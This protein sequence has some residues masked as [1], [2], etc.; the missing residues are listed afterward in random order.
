MVEGRLDCENSRH[1]T[2]VGSHD[3]GPWSRVCLQ[4]CGFCYHANVCTKLHLFFVY[5][6]YGNKKT[7]AVTT[8]VKYILH[9]HIIYSELMYHIQ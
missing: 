9:K 8:A 1:L 6:F 5:W 2:V 3:T 4:L 7:A